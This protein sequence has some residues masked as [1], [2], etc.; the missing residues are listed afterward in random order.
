M[1][2]VI[3]IPV[4]MAASRFPNKPMALIDGTPMIVHVWQRAVE[5][6]LGRVV[7]ACCDKDVKDC[8]ESNGGYVVLTNPDL[9][10][11][12]DRVYEAIE[13]D[14]EFSISDNIINLQGDM[15]LINKNSIESVIEPLI[16]GYDM[17]T[18]ATSFLS[19][20]EKSSQNITKVRIQWIKKEIMGEAVD[21]NKNI[22]EIGKKDV[23]HHLGIYGFKPSALK[24]FVKLPVSKRE[25]KLKL[26]QMRAID[27][28]ISIGINYVKDSLLGVDTMDDLNIV[29]KIIKDKK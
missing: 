23:Y 28:N 5:S 7:V 21:F 15:P 24:Q 17:S 12:T 10:S 25:K 18:L 16:Q 26:E 2:T 9:P 3:V 6:N 1:K 22:D 27:N 19:D 13:N 8:I 29:E 4:R 20:N 11:G 14:E